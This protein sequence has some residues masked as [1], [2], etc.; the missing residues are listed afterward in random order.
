MFAIFNWKKYNKDYHNI[1]KAKENSFLDSSFYQ[2]M[3]YLKSWHKLK[4][5]SQ[6]KNI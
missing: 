5:P 6:Y 4:I 2:M 1:Q 3:G